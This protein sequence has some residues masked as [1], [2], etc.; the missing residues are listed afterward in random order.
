MTNNL[1][2]LE[3]EQQFPASL[4]GDLPFPKLWQF[5]CRFVQVIAVDIGLCQDF[6]IPGVGEYGRLQQ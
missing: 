6:A 1:G 3:G 4:Q 5:G 2:K